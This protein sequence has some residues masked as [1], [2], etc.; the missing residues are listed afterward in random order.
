VI[1]ELLAYELDGSVDLV[2]EPEG[3]RCRMRLPLARIE[4][5]T[6]VPKPGS[7]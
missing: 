7:R 5:K 4:A 1:E 2:F 3:L 6:A